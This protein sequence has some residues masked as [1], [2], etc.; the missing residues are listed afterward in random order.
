MI[1]ALAVLVSG[2]DFSR[3]SIPIEDI[4]SGGPGKDGIPA[5][6]NPRFVGAAQAGFLLDA[7][8]VLGLSRGGEA[9][10]YPLRI[11]NWHELVND[12]LGGLPVLITYCP[13]CGTGMAFDP[14]LK[15]KRYTFGVS[16]LL[17]NSDVLM[18]DLQ[19][20]SL[21]SQIKREA[22][23]GPMTGTR[24]Q[25]VF[26]VH[27]TWGEW[28]R[29]HPDTKVLSDRTGYDRDYERD[30]YAEYRRSRGLWFAVQKSSAHFHPKEWVLGVVIGG[31]AKAYAFSDLTGQPS[32]FTDRVKEVPIQVHF[33]SESRNAFVTD[34][35]GEPIPS[36]VGFW[37]AW[38]AFYP[39]TMIYSPAPLPRRD[40]LP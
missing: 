7:D 20:E 35:Q 26:L 10:A 21:W 40:G 34:M 27:T 39:E 9:K 36:V 18:Y 14:V 33:H 15:G 22:V 5:L 4:E 11:L 16:G 13:L 30:P 17:Y 38:Y 8:R 37:F 12:E 2:F 25:P 28:R 3:H 24:L 29:E 32:V 6:H 23:T 19:T 31:A 1:L